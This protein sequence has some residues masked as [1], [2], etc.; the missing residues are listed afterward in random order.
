MADELD[1]VENANMQFN[2]RTLEP[3]YKLHIGQAG[4][5]FTFEVAQKMGIP[6]N[7]I[8]RAKKKVEK[9]KLRL[10]KTI[11]KLQQERNSLLKSNQALDKA[12]K[13]A[14]AHSE[15]LNE[16]EGKIKEKLSHFQ[17]LYDNNQKDV[18]LWKKNKRIVKSLFP[19]Q[20]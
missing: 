18:E 3:L 13:K 10:D 2:P 8:N 1:G 9:E 17:E 12:Q 11:S 15:S 7:L 5:S 20:Q 19:K 14:Q 4:S 16:K 6:F